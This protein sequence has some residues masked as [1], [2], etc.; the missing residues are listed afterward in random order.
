M[1]D[2]DDIDMKEFLKRQPRSVVRALSK[3]DKERA[4]ENRKSKRTYLLGAVLA[5]E[6]RLK[7]EMLQDYEKDGS[8]IQT[9]LSSTGQMFPSMN[10]YERR[11]TRYEKHNKTWSAGDEQK[12]Q[13]LHR[14]LKER[15]RA[16]WIQRGKSA[17]RRNIITS[18]AKTATRA[19]TDKDRHQTRTTRFE[20]LRQD[21]ANRNAKSQ[22]LYK[23]RR[24]NA[25]RLVRRVNNRS[26]DVEM[27]L[28]RRQRLVQTRRAQTARL[29]RTHRRAQTSRIVTK[30][31]KKKTK[32]MVKPVTRRKIKPII[33]FD[34]L[35]R[36]AQRE[37]RLAVERK[38]IEDA[39]TDAL[40][41]E[42]FM[43]KKLLQMKI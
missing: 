3:E 13:T 32:K 43:R 23:M 15:D 28:L 7:R 9:R 2:I 24:E 18:R 21:I 37:K 33:M 14:H 29:V 19:M 25:T 30:K 31:K 10:E 26:V 42:A 12:V 38:I 22:L 41:V 11:V 36:R 34:L 5:C 40:E 27:K 6:E 35:K 39:R 1:R 8:S 20:N 17:G 4:Y 16:Y